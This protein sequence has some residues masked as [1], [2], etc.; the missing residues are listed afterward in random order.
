MSSESPDARERKFRA[1]NQIAIVPFENMDF[2]QFKESLDAAAVICGL[3]ATFH[4]DFYLTCDIS[5]V[6]RKRNQRDAIRVITLIR[7]QLKEAGRPYYHLVVTNHDLFARNL[8]FVFGLT[9]WEMGV[10]IMSIFRLV[11]WQEDLTPS[12]MQERI[13]KEASHE[14]GHLRGLSHCERPT[15]LMAFSNTLEDVDAKLPMP[16]ARCSMRLRVAGK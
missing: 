10:A 12:K 11:Q 2:S 8:N 14:I 5:L 4:S 13:M 6:E 7:E 1:R 3:D 15:C 9:N 16:C